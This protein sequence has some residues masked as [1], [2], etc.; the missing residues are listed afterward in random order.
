MRK[1]QEF[2]WAIEHEQEHI[3]DILP[4][5]LYLQGIFNQMKKEKAGALYLPGLPDDVK[6]YKELCLLRLDDIIIRIKLRMKQNAD[7]PYSTFTDEELDHLH[8]IINTKVQ[9][10]TADK[11]ALEAGAASHFFQSIPQF[12]DQ[13]TQTDD[14]EMIKKCH[15]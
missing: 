1:F 6:N 2:K 7:E 15:F 14:Q 4:T 13:G 5:L 8:V 9:A 12:K 11:T 3:Y 10:L